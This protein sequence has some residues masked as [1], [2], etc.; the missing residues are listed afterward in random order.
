MDG[1]G[2][3]PKA[4]HAAQR[5]ADRLL[6]FYTRPE[7]PS[8]PGG[9]NQLLAEINDE[10]F[11]WGFVE[12]TRLPLGATTATVA[13]FS[14]DQRLT[15]FHI[16]DSLAAWFDGDRCRPLTR[17]HSE[18]RTLRRYLGQGPA[19]ELDQ[20]TIEFEDGDILCLVTDG[21]TKVMSVEEI[22]A[23]LRDLGARPER[24]AQELA[25][26][27]R[28]RHSPDDITALVVQLEEW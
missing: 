15:A 8:T 4:I 27:A 19:F 2:S 13:W 10:I 20:T 24:A 6:E 22:G 26:T 28:G 7:I 3:A 9:L 21:V 5:V 1:V 23:V 18:G 25:E 14:P 12:G 16:G 11:G 17:D